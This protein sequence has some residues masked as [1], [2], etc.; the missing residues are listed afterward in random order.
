MI[1]TAVGTI[2]TAVAVIVA[3]IANYWTNKNSEKNRE[4]QIALL[5]QQREQQKLD[6][7]VQNVILLNKMMRPLDIL[8]YSSKFV[9]EKFTQEDR[10]YLETLAVDDESMM[11]KI[12]VLEAVWKG[13]S[14]RSVLTCLHEL[15]ENYGLWSRSVTVLFQH[16]M[17]YKGLG[18]WYFGEKTVMA[19]VIREMLDKCVACNPAHSDFVERIERDG[20]NS[21]EKARLVLE[22]LGPELAKCVKKQKNKLE[23]VLQEF[24]RIEQKRIDDMVA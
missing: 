24:V 2:A 1:W 12:Y 4:L 21:Y 20:N 18:P 23:K 22:V 13:A 16:K 17:E 11:T 14:V 7:L 9:E 19:Q 8:H 6:E 3:L 10:S 5:Q 15:R